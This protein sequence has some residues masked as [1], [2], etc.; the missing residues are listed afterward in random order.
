MSRTRKDARGRWYRN[1]RGGKQARVRRSLHGGRERAV[2]PD[3]YD[4]KHVGRHSNVPQHA[5]EHMFQQGFDSEKAIH[6]LMGKFKIP[7]S[8]ASEIIKRAWECGTD[9][10]VLK[11]I[12][13]M[14]SQ[15]CKD[16]KIVSYL[17]K[18]YGLKENDAK[19]MVERRRCRTWVIS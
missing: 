12:R 8:Q 9:A 16:D 19:V 3:S 15:G 11:K 13:Q 18:H 2:P 7:H 6:K 4:D 14:I 17:V 1:P 10:K 5:A